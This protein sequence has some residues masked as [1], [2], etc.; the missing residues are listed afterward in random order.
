[1]RKLQH[2]KIC[3]L[4]GTLQEAADILSEMGNADA[5][6]R[7]VSDMLFFVDEITRYVEGIANTSQLVSALEALGGTLSS[8]IESREQTCSACCD[9]GADCGN[10]LERLDDVKKGCH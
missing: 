10:V 2:G 8:M 7:L 9:R 5:R 4:L 1:M 3:E 6:G